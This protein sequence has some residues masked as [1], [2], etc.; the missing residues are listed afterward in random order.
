M[1]VCSTCMDTDESFI[2]MCLVA[3]YIKTSDSFAGIPTPP[4][5]PPVTETNSSL[6]NSAMMNSTVVIP[7]SQTGKRL[8]KAK[9][10]IEVYN[11]NSTLN[12]A[13]KQLCNMFLLHFDS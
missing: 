1:Y 6:T 4:T 2:A 11:N 13:E 5:S 10:T 7:M 8:V 12:F 9:G 3:W